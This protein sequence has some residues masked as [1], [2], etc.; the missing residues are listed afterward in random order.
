MNRTECFFFF[1]TSE[2]LKL[3]GT[4]RSSVGKMEK[5]ATSNWNEVWYFERGS[6]DRWRV[7]GSK[8]KK[9]KGGKKLGF[10]ALSARSIG[11]I[12]IHTRHYRR[13]ADGNRARYRAIA[14]S[15]RLMPPSY[16]RFTGITRYFANSASF[17]SSSFSI[18]R[19]ILRLLSI[20]FNVHHGKFSK[21]PFNVSRAN[22][23]LN[24]N[25]II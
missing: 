16:T 15:C 7:A 21:Y 10:R 11:L 12:E 3:C 25:F 2:K 20:S 18:I 14:S 24:L 9:K 13:F 17:L 1:S 4:L 23:R 8:K 6:T 19:K 22:L 5:C